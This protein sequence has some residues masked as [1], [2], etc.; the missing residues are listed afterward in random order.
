MFS[1]Y[2]CSYLKQKKFFFFT[3]PLSKKIKEG[4]RWPSGGK[5]H[6]FGQT[7]I[8]GRWGV[9]KSA[10]PIS[11]MLHTPLQGISISIKNKKVLPV[12]SYVMP[13]NQKSWLPPPLWHS[14]S[15]FSRFV[16]RCY[17]WNRKNDLLKKTEKYI[18]SLQ[19]KDKLREQLFIQNQRI[20]EILSVYR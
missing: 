12:K 9:Q 8:S 20:Y 13:K 11:A 18:S 19:E 3:S 2:I 15:V 5:T 7:E 17:E 14:M 4:G 1:K 16:L 10:G 6:F